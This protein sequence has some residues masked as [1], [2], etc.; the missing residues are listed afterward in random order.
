MYQRIL[1]PTDGSELA[2]RGVTHGLALA[3]SVGALFRL[4][5]QSQSPD[6]Y[7]TSCAL[8]SA[9]TWRMARASR[10]GSCAPETA[11]FCANT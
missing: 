10:F 11:Y 9:D 5:Q 6:D 4:V 7:S 2:E 3:K 8:I 1:I